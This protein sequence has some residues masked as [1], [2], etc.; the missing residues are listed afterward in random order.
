MPPSKP[1]DL[2]SAPDWS[3]APLERTWRS[4]SILCWSTGL[5]LAWLHPLP[6][7]A[8][9]LVGW[10]AQCKAAPLTARTAPWPAR[11]VQRVEAG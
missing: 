11:R 3:Q 2:P 4:F 8:F 6:G 7:I 5:I 9:G 1:T 10:W